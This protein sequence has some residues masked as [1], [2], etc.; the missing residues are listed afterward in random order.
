MSKDDAFKN[1]LDIKRLWFSQLIWGRLAYN[2]ETP[3]SV[4]LDKLAVR[5]PGVPS[6]QLFEAWRNASHGLPLATEVIQGTLCFDFHWWPEFCQGNK[7]FLKIKDFIKAK[8]PG[9]STVSSIADTAAGTAGEA[10][11]TYEVADEIQTSGEEA[12]KILATLS[13]ENNPKLAIQLKN[14]TA[15]A[16]LSLYYAE[17]IRGATD[18][19]ADKKEEAK[20]AMGNA[21]GHWQNYVSIMDS[22][23]YGADM[24]RSKNFK[25]WRVHDAA[26]LKEYTDLGGQP[27]D[28]KSN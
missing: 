1:E 12:L 8:P 22:L 9:G 14:I 18:F 27:E 6:P 20:T 2:P 13:P 17:K 3:D 25:N 21:V 4:F 10:R 28:L 19:A 15:Q 11:T 23:Y 24:T 16:Y 26:V 5:Y 7:G